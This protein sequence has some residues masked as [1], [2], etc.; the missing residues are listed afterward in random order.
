MEN[1]TVYKPKHK[2]RFVTAA[3]LFDGHDATINIMRRILQSSGAEVIHLGHNRSVEEV[4]TCAIQEDVQGIAMTSYQ[5]GHI[6]YFKYM[7]DLLKERG[8]GHIKIFGGGGGVILPDEI[9]ELQQYG[10]AKIFSPDDGRRMG[11]QGMINSMLEQCDFETKTSLNGELKHLP[12]KDNKAIAQLITLAENHPEQFRA[13]LKAPS[14]LERAAGEAIPVLG[15]TGTGGAGKSSLVDEI[16]RRFLAETDK[17]LA[18]I[19]VDPS[20]RKTGGALLGD[21]IRMN[22]I[23]SPR[24]YMRSLATRQ[25]NLALSGYVQESIDICKAAGFDLIIVETSGIGQSDTMITDYCDVALYVMTPEFGAATQ[26]E[27]IDML[28]F[29]DLVAINK[30]DKRG[31]LDAIRDVRRQYKRNHMLFDARDEDMPVYGTMASQFNDPGMNSLFDALMK[32]IKEKTGIAF[33]PVVP[34]DVEEPEKSYVIPPD[35]IRY[36]AEIAESSTAY[37]NWVNEQCKIA[38]QLYQLQGSISLSQNFSKGEDFTAGLQDIYNQLEEHLHPDCKR[39]LK[40]WPDTLLR[41]KADNFIYRVR[42]K[43]IKQPLFTTSLSQLRI[44]K[45]ALPKYE[46]WGDILRWLLTENVPGEFPYAAGVF[47]LKRDGEDP[48]RMFA[49]EGGPE[50]TNKRFH[51]VS[52][53]QPA[54]RLSTA[55]DSV[56]LYG[57]DPH[58]RPD[59]YGK[60]GNSGVS[61]AT[62]DDAKKLYSG[63]DLCSPST[64][65]SMTINGPAPML[66]GFFMNAAIDQQCEKYIIE[67][68]LEHLVEAKFKE[69]YDDNGLARPGYSASP[70]PSPKERELNQ[71]YGYETADLKF[72]EILKNNSKLN[73]QNPTEAEKTLWANLRN[74]QTGFKI[75]RQHAVDGYIADFICLGKGLII[76]V[77]GGYHE[78]TKEQDEIRTKILKEK[79]FDVIRFNNEDVLNNTKQ[80]VEKI[81]NQLNQQPE[82]KVLSFGE[83]LG[84]ALLPE[85][86]NGLGLMLLGL[87]GDQVL[88]ADVYQKI[89]AYAISTVRGT[90]QADILKEDQAQ[91]TCIFSTEFA[92]RMM[93]DIQQYFIDEKVRNFYSVSISG[94]HIAEA[95]ANPI[96]QLAFT[97]ANGFTYVEYYLSRGM[98]IDD[99]APN[100]SFFFSNGIDP[101]YAVIGRVARRIWAKAIKNKYKGN[102]RSQKLKYH[103]QTSGRSLHAQEI[104]FNDIRT[105]LQALYAIYDNCNSLHTNAYDEAITTPTEE[106]VRRAMAIQ[107]IINRELGLAKNE[108]PIQ[109]AFIIEEL[110]DLV[111]EAVLTEFKRINDRGGVLGAMETMYQRSKI[112]E[113]SLYYETLKHTGEYPIIG[114]NTFLNKKGSPTLIPAEVIRATEEE[115][116]YQIAALEAFQQ[117][118]ADK[119]PAMLKNLQHSATSGEN[120]FQQLMEACKYCSLGQISHALYQVGG[121]YRRNM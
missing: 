63:F 49:G 113:E 56:T 68:K 86:N 102:D 81:T 59:I 94:Y 84:E 100:L 1:I 24:I 43:E 92:L 117:R 85:G 29:A 80:V 65:V 3:S 79:G 11:L 77:D 52:L 78:Y 5:G 22:A 99:F 40:E 57:E 60:I 76:E 110:T 61:I 14:L 105:T 120:I 114:V 20:K 89:K 44:P 66:L 47:P 96:T 121:Q 119:A 7:F 30:F 32:V 87:T 51:Y 82:R 72:W 12:E 103:I 111:E 115:K 109:G 28:D 58:T 21:R 88:P 13:S 62:L 98:H 18:I 10:I 108:N 69:L 75:R 74:N 91:N 15:I 37:N 26:L 50:R 95:G 83:D 46:A 70:Q 2:V 33:N 90:V 34:T 42:D 27:K 41:Y 45:V 38:Q 118:N 97:L 48:T 19:S 31:A 8:A 16:V 112:Q 35:R 67:N 54:H 39:L 25:A 17:T 73:R 64:S 23:N 93:G 116:Q 53:G 55:F 107:L 106:S 36:L 9:E 6:E 104:D 101:E 71:H 4:V